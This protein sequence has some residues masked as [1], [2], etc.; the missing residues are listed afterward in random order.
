MTRSMLFIILFLIFSKNIFAIGR[1]VIDSVNIEVFGEN[2]KT[3]ITN[4]IEMIEESVSTISSVSET[5]NNALDIYNDTSRQLQSLTKSYSYSSSLSNILEDN[6]ENI[7]PQNYTI[8]PKIINGKKLTP[9]NIVDIKILYQNLYGQD[10]RERELKKPL[11][12]SHISNSQE[13]ALAYCEYLI[14]NSPKK[15][16]QINKSIDDS[17]KSDELKQAQDITNKQLLQILITLEESKLLL[18]KNNRAMLLSDNIYYQRNSNIKEKTRIEREE[19]KEGSIF[20]KKALM[21]KS[22]GRESFWNR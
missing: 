14:T 5:A 22:D 3:N 17:S 10:E 18:A 2:Q 13:D 15:I 1:P 4:T 16:E 12:H 9:E 21:P 19:D 6:L 11:I 7:F 20:R 8:D